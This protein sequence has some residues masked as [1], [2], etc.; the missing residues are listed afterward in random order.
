MCRFSDTSY[1]QRIEYVFP[2]VN[3]R[4]FLVRIACR[5]FGPFFL[6]SF[7]TK[8]NYV[9]RAKAHTYREVQRTDVPVI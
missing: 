6:S 5:R 2:A 8:L 3:S 1:F 7:Y 9:I 4:N